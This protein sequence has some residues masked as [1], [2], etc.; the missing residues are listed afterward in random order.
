VDGDPAFGRVAHFPDAPVSLASGPAWLAERCE[1]FGPVPCAYL[2]SID[3]STERHDESVNRSPKGAADG[4][5]EATADE[6]PWFGRRLRAVSG[7]PESVRL[8]CVR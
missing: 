6:R 8:Y 4:S 5:P 2:L 1:Q 3:S 7:L